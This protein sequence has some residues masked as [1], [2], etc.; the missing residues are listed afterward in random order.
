MVL[1]VVASLDLIIVFQCSFAG[2]FLFRRNGSAVA[3]DSSLP[4]ATHKD[5]TNRFKHKH[6]F[7]LPNS[8]LL[9]SHLQ[10]QLWQELTASPPSLPLL[11]IEQLRTKTQL[12]KR[13]NRHLVAAPQGQVRTVEVVADEAHDTYELYLRIRALP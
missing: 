3:P 2:C 1:F 6:S 7:E 13:V 12:T 9:T 5:C 11:L 10:N 4:E 8:Y